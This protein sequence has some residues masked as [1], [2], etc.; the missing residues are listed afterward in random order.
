MNRE[1]PVFKVFIATCGDFAGEKITKW[2]VLDEWYKTTGTPRPKHPFDNRPDVIC[3]TQSDKRVGVELKAWLN[4]WQ[5]AEAKRQERFE[6]T[7]LKAIG[8]LPRNVHKY[9]KRIWL[10]AKPKRFNN[11]D[12]HELRN[13]LFDLIRRV[14]EN[15]AAKPDWEKSSREM[16]K[17]LSGSPTLARYI[18]YVEA[19]PRREPIEPGQLMNEKYHDRRW[20]GFPNRGGAYSLDEMLVPLKEVL[21]ETKADKRYKDICEHVGLD[22]CYLLVHYD[23]DAFAYN[24]PID[25][26]DYSFRDVVEFGRR[27]IAKDGGFF[28]R[29]FLLNCLQG[30]EEAHRLV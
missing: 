22:E 29:I 3:V 6:E 25:V 15:W 18:D 4:E 12:S 17:D 9:I 16:I 28:Q 13:Q 30:H 2:Q 1:E 27:V 7:I 26:P 24:S 14:D 23:F 5:I 19:F 10:R 8:E 21:L 20:I 11:N